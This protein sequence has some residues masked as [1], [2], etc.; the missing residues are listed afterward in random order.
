METTE[1]A[2]ATRTVTILAQ[3]LG[4]AEA[5]SAELAARLGAAEAK[6]AELAAQLE[7]AKAAKPIDLAKLPGM[8]GQTAAPFTPPSAAALPRPPPREPLRTSSPASDNQ[9]PEAA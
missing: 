3:K 1:T 7:E 8:E 2:I 6:V 4:A 9:E 5:Q